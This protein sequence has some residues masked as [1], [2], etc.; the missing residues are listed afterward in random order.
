MGPGDALCS[1]G[2][3]K[4]F[5]V[6]ST[7]KI[8]LAKTVIVAGRKLHGYLVAY[9]TFY[10]KNVKAS[11]GFFVANRFLKFGK[12]TNFELCLKLYCFRLDAVVSN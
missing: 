3:L 9:L 4:Y 11:K 8:H 5:F 7:L 6:N 10:L 1:V 12:P 2:H